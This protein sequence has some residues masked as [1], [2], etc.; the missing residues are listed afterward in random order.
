L[1]GQIRTDSRNSLGG[2]EG[3]WPLHSSIFPAL[4]LTSQT[5]ARL[6]RLEALA[7][8]GVKRDNIFQYF[9]SRIYAPMVLR[10]QQDSY[11]QNMVRANFRNGALFIHGDMIL[12]YERNEVK[13]P[14]GKARRIG[15]EDTL[16]IGR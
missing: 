11:P 16:S 9:V 10:L 5:C 4:P 8:S 13:P 2:P 7:L 14:S 3:T 15:S 1:D 6:L 12:D